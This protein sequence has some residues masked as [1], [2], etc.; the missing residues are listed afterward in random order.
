MATPEF[1]SFLPFRIQL[2]KN[3]ILLIYDIIIMRFMLATEQTEQ[4]FPTKSLNAIN[5]GIHNAVKHRTVAA[6]LCIF[7]NFN[8]LAKS[9]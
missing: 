8:P 1:L 3:F 4:H 6:R 2:S 5:F 9:N 7:L